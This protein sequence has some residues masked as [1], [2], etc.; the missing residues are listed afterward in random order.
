MSDSP[1]RTTLGIRLAAMTLLLVVLAGLLVWAGTLSPADD[2]R[3]VP[4]NDE[5]GQDQDAYVGERVSLSGT[6]VETDP[7]VIDVEYGTG[8]TFTATVAGVDESVS[9]GDQMTAFGTLESSS[10]LAAERVIV[11][12]PWE[13]WY[14]YGVSFLGGLWVLLRTVRRWRFDTDRLAFVPRERPLWGGRDA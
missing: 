9:E 4:G 10:T 7:V 2:P 5:V 14:M 1:A 8:E 11:R 3:D 13:L 6:V 12:E